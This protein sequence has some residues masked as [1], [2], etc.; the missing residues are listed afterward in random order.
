[1]KDEGYGLEVGHQA[2]LVVLPGDTPAHAVV[3]SPPRS[4]VVKNGRIVARVGKL[5]P[6][7]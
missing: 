5:E 1:M 4:L 6:L 3:E 7:V 2:D